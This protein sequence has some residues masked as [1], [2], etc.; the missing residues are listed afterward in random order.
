MWKCHVLCGSELIGQFRVFS[1]FSCLID[2]LCKENV[3]HFDKHR[4]GLT[5]LRISQWKR[6]IQTLGCEA[7]S[8]TVNASIVICFGTRNSQYFIWF[9]IC[10]FAPWTSLL[11]GKTLYGIFLASLFLFLH[12]RPTHFQPVFIPEA[13]SVLWV[14]YEYFVL[15]SGVIHF[16]I[17]LTLKNIN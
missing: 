1:I 9:R 3:F 16:S 15:Y 14:H 5:W 13:I 10:C 6:K 2:I 4:T 7:K 8:F 11:Q 12:T 17:L